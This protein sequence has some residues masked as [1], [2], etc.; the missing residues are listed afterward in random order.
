MCVEVVEEREPRPLATPFPCQEVVGDRRRPQ[1]FVDAHPSPEEGAPAIQPLP[2]QGAAHGGAHREREVLVAPEAAGQP[3]FA[4]GRHQVGHEAPGPVPARGELPGEGRRAG[5]QGRPPAYREVLRVQAGEHPRVRAEGPRRGAHGLFEGHARGRAAERLRRGGAG[6]AVQA[7]A[8]RPHRVPDDQ[9]HV[10]AAA[11]RRAAHG[12]SFPQPVTRDE[13]DRHQQHRGD[14]PRQAAA[15]Q[16]RRGHATA[17]LEPDPD[18]QQ[19]VRRPVQQASEQQRREHR[20]A[21]EPRHARQAGPGTQARGQADGQGR[22]HREGDRRRQVHQG[23]HPED[24]GRRPHGLV[25]HEPAE[26]EDRAL[27]QAGEQA[28]P[29]QQARAIHGTGGGG[30]GHGRKWTRSIIARKT[31]SRACP[32]LS[33]A[34]LCASSGSRSK[35][36]RRSSRVSRLRM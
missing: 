12:A 16:R 32:T 5:A 1:R 6:V 15:G 21:Q 24:V 10:R 20:R 33:G 2:E 35:S 17:V 31:G 14:Q 26:G 23:R 36:K 30:L 18:G 9:Q 4:R 13:S 19:Q 34:R 3:A 8:L 22:G 7:E 28:G 11:R 25:L 29:Q 27:D